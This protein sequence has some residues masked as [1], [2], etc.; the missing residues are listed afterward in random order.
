MRAHIP[1]GL[2]GRVVQEEHK[3]PH[4]PIASGQGEFVEEEAGGRVCERA[5]ERQCGQKE[6][7][8][9]SQQRS[10]ESEWAELDR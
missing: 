2:H 10:G 6:R 9:E 1:R 7:V 8:V 5:C 3:L 4:M